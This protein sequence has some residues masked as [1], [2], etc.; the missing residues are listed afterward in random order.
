ME[1][2]MRSRVETALEFAHDRLQKSLGA[3]DSDST[4]IFPF[5]EKPDGSWVLAQAANWTAGY[6][7]GQL[8]LTE[9]ISKTGELTDASGPWMDK[10]RDSLGH[11]V[12]IGNRIF[13]SYGNAYLLTNADKDLDL[14]VRACEALATKQRPEFGC[15]DIFDDFGK[16]G[17]FRFMV[18]HLNN[19]EL[20]FFT[21]AATDNQE[22]HELA[23]VHTRKVVD[24]LVRAD[25][26]T[27]QLAHYD[28]PGGQFIRHVT[29]QG[30]SN[31]ST[32]SRGQAWAV[33]GLPMAY[34]YTQDSALLEA[35]RKVADFYVGRLPESGVPLWDFQLPSDDP[36]RIEDS[37]ASSMALCGLLRLS[38]LSQ[39]A[40]ESDRYRTDAERI[41]DGLLTPTY[42]AEETK[43]HAILK[44][45]ALNVPSQKGIGVGT[46]WGD[47]F[48]VESLVRYLT[49]FG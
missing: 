49:M 47:Y 19:L 13:H 21:A 42:L 5:Y 4:D 3:I 18:D 32:W 35:S 30:Y 10:L 20:L 8:F 1:N 48:L 27:F 40:G 41:L 44:A 23:L 46:S 17:P 11:I 26:S 16:D 22:W 43:H 34:Q 9:R 2:D 15:L 36:R 39:E 31:D 29:S 45:G 28:Q 25:G 7:P 37:S 24:E 38:G 6:F 12:E 33:N 14:M